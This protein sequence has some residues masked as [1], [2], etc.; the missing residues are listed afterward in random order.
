MNKI[1]VKDYVRQMY[2]L[3]NNI[4]YIRNR[5]YQFDENMSIN[6]AA[7]STLNV[8]DMNQG[9]NCLELSQRMGISKSA[10]SQTVKKLETLGLIERGS[11]GG[12]GKEVI[13][14]LTDKG[15]KVLTTY[16]CVHD[17]YYQSVNEILQH[18]D[19]DQANVIMEYLVRM[20]NYFDGFNPKLN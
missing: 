17:E 20:N 10:V 1:N 7:L 3:S 15:R 19:D 14:Y 8:I 18:F 2:R 16:R 12:N 9:D 13:P 4:Q 6:S 5:N 11:K